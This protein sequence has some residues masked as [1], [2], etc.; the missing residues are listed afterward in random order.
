MKKANIGLRSFL[1]PGIEL[2]AE[3]KSFLSVADKI[4]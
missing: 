3:I 2:R 4:L 1:P